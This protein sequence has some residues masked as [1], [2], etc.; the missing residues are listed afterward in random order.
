MGGATADRFSLRD[1]FRQ[2]GGVP[3]DYRRRTASPGE[4]EVR[5]VR[6]VHVP[7]CGAAYGALTFRVGTADESVPLRGI[8]HLVEHLVMREAHN[9]D[10]RCNAGVD[11]ARTTFW[12]SGDEADVVDFL[13][14][15]ERGIRVLPVQHLASERDLIAVEEEH[16]AV[17]LPSPVQHFGA[18]R[19]GVVWFEQQLAHLEPAHLTAWVR[20]RFTADN[21]VLTLAGVEPHRVALRLPAGRFHPEPPVH[22]RTEG[23][24]L[25]VEPTEKTTTLTALTAASWQVP[26]LV[27]VLD[28]AVMNRLRH[29]EH[30]AY[31][32]GAREV[33]VNST[34]SMV[35]MTS[36][37][38]P[39]REPELVDALLDELRS[40]TSQV[41][42]DLVMRSMRRVVDDAEEGSA[43]RELTERA[44]HVLH[45]TAPPVSSATME[46]ELEVITAAS[47]RD[48]LRELLANCVLR[49]PV[50]VRPRGSWRRDGDAPVQ[51]WAG[52]RAF[53]SIDGTRRLELSGNGLQDGAHQLT[54]SSL[55]AAFVTDDV[56]TL[57][58][59]RGVRLDVRPGEW[60][61]G[62]ELLAEL[63]DRVPT[64]VRLPG[65]WRRALIQNA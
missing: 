59:R 47:L 6:T 45:G 37:C 43:M 19:Y 39:G 35:V 53:V 65:P 32:A 33:R 58:S 42:E 3:I 20:E 17:S 60:R 55:T 48:L 41:P 34:T 64:A 62:G 22:R 13:R 50:P 29:V 40:L 25:H 1:R 9:V 54:W 23:P 4:P 12:A 61:T 8:T 24:T 38:V 16:H 18:Q 51:T 56:W 46:S 44:M 7:T 14:R 63:R 10:V 49:T 30:L 2:A 27:G 28:R 5:P 31:G 11:L 21:A 57:V 26:V 52:T 36:D 15:V